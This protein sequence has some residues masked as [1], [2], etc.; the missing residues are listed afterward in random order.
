MNTHRLLICTALAL[1]GVL[2]GC[3]GGDDGNVDDTAMA[4]DA[5]GKVPPSATASILAFVGFV[6]RQAPADQAEPLS[7]EGATP[8]TSET[9]E[10]QPLS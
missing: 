1:A 10:P 8:P 4:E 2:A 9:E 6:G 3:G 5:T 7:L